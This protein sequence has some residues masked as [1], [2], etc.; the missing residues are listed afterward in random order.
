MGKPI[1]EL[2]ARSAILSGAMLKVLLILLAL[3][4][5]VFII[6]ALTV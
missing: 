4:I 1:F 5:A 6:I 3:V 2:K